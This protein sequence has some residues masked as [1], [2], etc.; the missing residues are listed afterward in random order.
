MRT[1]SST[2]LSA[3]KG[4]STLP[5]LKAEVDEA[6][7][8]IARPLF[9]RVY[10]G[11][12]PP[13]HHAAFM[14]SDGS[15]IRARMEGTT[16]KVYVQRVVNPDESSDYSRWRF[17]NYAAREAT[18][19]LCGRGSQVFLFYVDR[20]NKRT[21][22]Y[23]EST[24]NGASWSAE[25]L[26]FH[27][28]GYTVLWVAAAVNPSGKVAL[29][30]IASGTIF[31]TIRTGR[32][33][34]NPRHWPYIGKATNLKSISCVYGVDWNLVVCGKTSANASKVWTTIYGDGGDVTSLAWSSL[35]ELTLAES[36]AKVEFLH[37]SLADIDTF[38]LF[39][40]EKFT[41]AASYRRPLWSF[42]PPNA[43]YRDSL[44]REPVP[45]NLNASYGLAIA[46]RGGNLWL[47][48]SS[49]VWRG[50]FTSS[51]DI[52][53]DILEADVVETPFHGRAVLVLRNDDGKYNSPGTGA[54]ASLHKGS[55]LRL[56]PGYVTLRGPK[57][58]LGLPS[59]SR[60]WS[61]AHLMAALSWCFTWKT[62]GPSCDGGERAAGTA[63]A[64]AI[65]R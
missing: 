31:V 55:R 54:I 56:S 62:P 37:S 58:P 46:G 22:R 33:W 13:H 64:G 2:L 34:S 61:T 29:F 40:L 44:W 4:A 25:K 41:G 59:G 10:T 21:L 38:R 43:L 15:L 45:F 28:T 6:F 17:M 18:I 63:G 11:V 16:Q 14:P 60:A 53:E 1:L 3:Q 8:A 35:K 32:S 12:E 36:N 19:C 24:N 23:R 47:S 39:F 7:P 52:T 65:P 57:A 9:T 49:G 30:Y 51:L 50:T 26:V 20:D 48:T 42:T 5:Y 27:P